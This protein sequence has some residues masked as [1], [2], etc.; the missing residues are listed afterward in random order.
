MPDIR[1]TD[2]NVTLPR[3]FGRGFFV[4]GGG[5]FGCNASIQYFEQTRTN[6]SAMS[7]SGAK[8]A[9]RISQGGRNRET[10]FIFYAPRCPLIDDVVSTGIA[11][12][13]IR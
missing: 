4:S 1:F 2:P 7:D 11:S 8:N 3:P 13:Q 6:R 10:N 5:A 12:R 9:R